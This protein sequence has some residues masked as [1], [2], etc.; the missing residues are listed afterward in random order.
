[1]PR[2]TNKK[3]LLLNKITLAAITIVT[4]IIQTQASFS[5]SGG[6]LVR[7]G[8]NQN[9]QIRQS[10][11]PWQRQRQHYQQPSQWRNAPYPQQQTRWNNDNSNSNSNSNSGGYVFRR[12]QPNPFYQQLP[13][14]LPQPK[15]QPNPFYQI[16]QPQPPTY[17]QPDPD[18][19]YNQNQPPT[20]YVRPPQPLPTVVQ[21]PPVPVV[22]FQP[23]PI[24]NPYVPI[25]D[26]GVEPDPVIEIIKPKEEDPPVVIVNPPTLGTPDIIE[27][28]SPI[29]PE[30]F[31]P[32][33]I[34]DSYPESKP[35]PAPN[36]IPIVTDPP[37]PETEVNPI[38]IDNGYY[39]T[40]T[41]EPTT[42]IDINDIP[43]RGDSP[44]SRNRGGNG[45]TDDGLGTSL[46]D[47][48]TGFIVNEP[49]S[50][51]GSSPNPST[52]TTNEIASNNPD[53]PPVLGQDPELDQQILAD[54]FGSLL[55]NL[56]Q[57]SKPTTS[58]PSPEV[59]EFIDSLYSNGNPFAMMNTVNDNMGPNDQMT[60][61]TL[62][63]NAA[64]RENVG[65]QGFANRPSG[66][67]YTGT[68]PFL[69]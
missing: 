44:Y 16:P 2:G 58:T 18:A 33:N 1:M 64:A 65:A 22:P 11:Q 62:N 46:D 24:Q 40:T 61:N 37:I 52:G 23:P 31:R 25:P 45:G 13:Q 7:G 12:P 5:G 8:W 41:P 43:N 68:N 20:V 67:Q 56:Q 51:V 3:M 60:R 10:F 6:M 28:P 30:T 36:P 34:I 32:I 39:P 17:V 14:P 42:T 27:S 53:T 55:N 4:I 38:L 35:D 15:P 48:E 54:V 49:Q 66:K 26:Y 63:S 50:L 21:P 47:L 29:I 9:Q 57:D 19:F 59:R 69:R